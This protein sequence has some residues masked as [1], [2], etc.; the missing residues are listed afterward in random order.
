V[1]PSSGV[2]DLGIYLLLSK[3]RRAEH[4]A[5]A[6]T[7]LACKKQRQWKTKARDVISSPSPSGLIICVDCAFLTMQLNPNSL[8]NIFGW[9]RQ[10]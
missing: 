2:K 10:A 6:R 8:P 5:S 9:R 1:R 7:P 4:R 3:N